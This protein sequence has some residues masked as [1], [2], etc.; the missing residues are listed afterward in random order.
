MCLKVDFPAGTSV[1]LQEQADYYTAFFQAPQQSKLGTMVTGI[2][3]WSWYLVRETL[4]EGTLAA[5]PLSIAENP[6]VHHSSGGAVGWGGAEMKPDKRLVVLTLVVGL[7][8]RLF[9][10]VSPVW[11]ETV[12]RHGIVEGDDSSES[13][14]LDDRE[15]GKEHAALESGVSSYR[16]PNLPIP[17]RVEDLLERMTLAEK[18]GQMT[19]IERRYLGSNSEAIINYYLGSVLSGPGSAPDAG[20]SPEDWADM[21]DHYQ[22]LALSTR[23]GIPLIYGT[24]AVHGHNNVYGATIFPH[25]IGL[26]ATRNPALTEEIARLTAIEV[27]ATG[28]DWTFA[29]CVAVARDERW[30]RTYESFGET[31][32]LPSMMTR[33]IGG[34]QGVDLSDR[35][36]ILATAKHYVG[37]GGTAGGVDQGNTELT[38]AELRAI[39]FP[40]YEEAVKA[41]VGSVMVSFSSWNGQK[42]HGHTYLISDVLKGELGFDGFVISDWA[43]IDQLPGDYS[44]DVNT[45]INAGIDMVMVPTDAEK[46]VTTLISEVNQGNVPTERIDDAVRRILTK[47]F[48]LGLFE[49]PYADRTNLDLIGSQAHRDVARRAVRE[50]LVLL[51]NEDNLLPLD[52]DLSTVLVA[53]ENADDVGHQCGGWTINWGGGSG[54][55]TPGTT[56]L[57]GIREIVA[58]TT[59]VTYV[60]EPIGTLMSDVGIVV[61]GET[62][63][64]EYEGDDDDL[65]LAEQDVNAINAVCDAMPCVVVLV[66]GRPMVIT[67]EISRADAFVAA[68]LP[69]TEGD[70]VAQVLFGDYSF[71]GKLPMSWPGSMDQIPVNVGDV[72]YA[73]LFA[74]GY[75]LRYPWLDFETPEYSVKEGGTAVVT[76][77]LNTTVTEPITVSYVASDG[78]ATAGSDYIATT[79]T[80]TFAAGAASQSAKTFTVQTIEDGDIEGNETI[81]LILFD[82]LGIKSGSPATLAIFDDDA[83]KQRPPLVGWKQVA[84]NGFG[85]P[86]NEEISALERFNGQLYAGASNYVEG[87]QIWRTED[88]FTWTQVTPL[89]LGTAYTNTNAVIFDMI[90]FKGQLY[91]GV[92]NWEDDGIPGQIWRS[93]N[94]VDWTLV[95]GEGFGSTHNAGIVNF[96]VFSNTLY[97]ATYNPSDG[98]EIWHSPTGN[99]DDWTSVVSGGNGDAQNVICTDLIQF[100]DALYAVIENESDGAE[101]WHTNN[102]I[103]WTRAITS[104][105][106]NADNTQTGGAVAFNGYLYVGTY[107]GTTGA[108]LW[109]FRDGTAGWMRVIGDGF[110]DGNN[111]KIESLA[112]FSDTLYAVTA[113]EVSG[114][115]VWRSLDGV[116]WSQANRDGFGDSDN[117][118]TLWSIATAVFNHELYIGTANRADG[119][120]VWASSDYR[121]FLPLAANNYAVPPVRGVTL[122]AHYEPD[123]FERYLEQ[124]LSKIAGLGANHV[125][126]AYVWYMTDRYASEVHPAPST[127]TPGQFGITHSITDVQRFVSEAHRLGLKVDLSLQLVCHFGLSGCWAGSIQPEDQAAWDVSYIYDYI[128]PMAD[129]AQELGVERLTI[130]NELESMQRREDFMLE[131]ISQVR[132]VYDGDIIIGLSMWGGDEFGGDA[133]FGGYRNVPASVL[134][135]VDYVGL[136]LYVSG[137]TDGDATI[138]EM[139]ARMIPQ[140]NSVAAYYQSIGVSN[141]TIPEAGASIMDGG[142]IIPWQVGFPEDTPLDLQEQA[143]YYAAFFQALERSELGPMVDGAI[144]WSWELAEETLEDGNL[145]VHRLSIARNPL[146]HQVLAEQWGGEVQ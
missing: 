97:A 133:G 18:V 32:E 12:S 79:G 7:S 73:P 130:A 34:Y 106:G 136:H 84:A 134:R 70:G 101:I 91:V 78:T 14:Y 135:A 77:T 110:G 104:G 81:E 57:E 13:A 68:W 82:A 109:R 89:G 20:N 66:S 138:E 85:N 19:Q 60:E 122:G 137:S 86:A 95:E 23:L 118:K 129:M 100:D 123:N 33:A 53:G 119:G 8:L 11:T 54:D 93:P 67:E 50:S 1:D 124:E 31:P 88:A 55:I 142:S 90:V 46:F 39:H 75:G 139:M 99:S 132:Q 2:T 141:L 64:A 125:G 98:L 48:E 42:I 41:G 143:D 117:A 111:V 107:N 115:E 56:I 131:L 114:T 69:G 36:T 38:E 103:T 121:I 127:W 28:V 30:G 47:K 24:D 80:I 37:D 27:A 9:F 145:D 102:G 4:G 21:Y 113:N 43:G 65:T 10:W 71:T 94:G 87:G 112:V 26:G 120:E 44:S 59:T 140:M 40:P 29:P 63:Y 5:R 146:V 96:G 45:A 3:F 58:A 49:N 16:N 35:Y 126:L 17:Q 83:S 62:P 25:N 74:Y 116:A 144:F 15:R 76:V 51:K 72:A 22:S 61:V 52:K 105:F 108:Q 128:V 92:G 6:L